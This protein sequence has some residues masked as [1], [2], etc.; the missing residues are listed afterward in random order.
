MKWNRLF[1][2]VVCIVFWGSVA[3]AKAPKGTRP[4]VVQRGESCWS[5]ALKVYGSGK[6]Y[7]IIH[8]HNRLGKLPHILKP[9]QIIYLPG[10]ARR[11]DAK[12]EWL[13]RRVQARPPRS[14]DWRR[15]KKRMNLWRLYKLKTGSQSSVGIRFDNRSFLR[16]RE[17]ALLVIYGK[18]AQRVQTRRVYKRTIVVQKGTVRG[19]LGSLFGGNQMLVKT[20]SSEVR[21]RSKLAQVEVD[22]KKTSSISVY[23]GHADVKAQG[24]KVR[25]P[26]DYGTFV[27]KGKK[28]AKPRPLP[29][30]PQWKDQLREAIVLMPRG[31]EGRMTFR[32][33]PVK[34]AARYRFEISRH[35]NFKINLAHETYPIRKKKVRLPGE[36]LISAVVGS[37]VLGFH[38]VG[39]KPGTYYVR[40]AAIDRHRLEGYPSRTLVIRVSYMGVSKTLRPSRDGAFESTGM[41]KLNPPKSSKKAPEVSLNKAPF[42]SFTSPI[43][44][45]KPGEHLIRFRPKGSEQVTSRLRVRLLPVRASLT[46]STKRL[47]INGSSVPISLQLKALHRPITAVN[48]KV[49]VSGIWRAVALPG[50]KVTAYPGGD[51]PVKI[52]RAGVYKGSLPAPKQFKQ[53]KVTLVASW[54][55]GELSRTTLTVKRPP[56]VVRRRP[57]PKKFVPVPLGPIFDW[58]SFAVGMEWVNNSIILP[59]R[60]ARPTTS[61]HLKA[62]LGEWTRRSSQPAN[63]ASSG[64][65]LR[66][67]FL[68]ELA[69][70]DKRLGIDFELPWLQM[71]IVQ[72]SVDQNKLGDIRVG[73]RYVVY[74]SKEWLLT[75]SLRISLPTGA[76]LGDSFANSPKLYKSTVLEPGLLLAWHPLEWM[77][78]HTNQ[79][80]VVQFDFDN[81]AGFFYT[82]AYGVEARFWKLA[83]GVELNM[84]MGSTLGSAF[85]LQGLGVSGTIQMHFNRVRIGAVVGGMLNSTGHNSIGGFSAGLTFALGFDGP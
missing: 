46:T 48:A 12:I 70:L 14:V 75:P 32:W 77:T 40:V 85:E 62:F 2:V 61:L 39:L 35:P 21:L 47:K 30:P 25:V 31:Q 81:K 69:L 55:G 37:G 78:L 51:V 72:D 13:R 22:K 29:S 17:Q 82:S 36:P 58:P 52:I 57:P 6:M 65:F 33:M 10:K 68:G 60:S 28:P 7:K 54:A 63:L 71:N 9:G 79:M 11:P 49:K 76:A 56:V 27:K 1:I 84:V 4:Y 5:I 73:A 83:L 18:S 34:R 66:M 24:A 42:K 20:P 8:K 23:D 45:I 50:V 3:E 19:G 38:Y 15:A 64:L 80:F 41:L 16:M 67:A 26:K 53:S 44:L 74:R 43:R 59:S